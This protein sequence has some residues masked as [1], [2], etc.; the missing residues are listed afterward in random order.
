MTRFWVH[1]TVDDTHRQVVEIKR[2]DSTY[3]I[4]YGLFIMTTPGPDE[5]M[6][7]LR[8]CIVEHFKTSVHEAGHAVAGELLGF[9]S[10]YIEG[11]FWLHDR[12][13][14]R[15]LRNWPHS[16]KAFKQNVGYAVTCIAGIAAEAIDEHGGKI[17]DELR[18][19]P[20]EIDYKAVAAIAQR[21]SVC[22]FDPLTLQVERS[23]ASLIAEW[24]T[25]AVELLKDNWEWVSN[26]AQLFIECEGRLSG[27]DVRS[28]KPSE[29]QD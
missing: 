11:A 23:E 6:Q 7:N 20:G 4:H 14:S 9:H 8:L 5:G 18:A 3:G 10:R 12:R 27:D 22:K 21:I 25:K 16:P 15:L 17:T 2:L 1:T 24:E 28:C 26:V 13:T 29:N 19:G